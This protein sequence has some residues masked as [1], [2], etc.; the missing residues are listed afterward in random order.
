[1][2]P[3]AETP[4]TTLTSTSFQ[5]GLRTSPINHSSK[6]RSHQKNE[7][8]PFTH[9][10][11]VDPKT[12]SLKWT[13]LSDILPLVNSEIE[14]AELVVKEPQPIVKIVNKKEAQE[15]R[16]QQKELKKLQLKKNAQKEFQFTWNMAAGDMAHK[17]E[18]V[19]DELRKGGRVDLVFAPKSK[20][21][22][23]TPDEMQSRAQELVESLADVGR[24]WKDREI[25]RGIAAIFLKGLEVPGNTEDQKTGEYTTT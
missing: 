23:P 12:G 10:Q 24:E 21:K 14:D 8:I 1:M 19:K 22:A 5:R 4:Y 18:R 13:A 6:Y 15:K 7:K 16:Q 25:K 9:V 11:F 3:S 2:R 17:L 20:Q